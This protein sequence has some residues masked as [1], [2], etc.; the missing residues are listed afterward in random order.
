MNGAE[1]K[2]GPIP[3]CTPPSP[4]EGCPSR[5]GPVSRLQRLGLPE[6][7][8]RFL[9][10]Y[11]EHA[12]D[13]WPASLAH[14]HVAYR[15]QVRSKVAAIRADQKEAESAAE[16][17]RLLAMA[18]RHLDEGHVRLV[19]VGGLPGTGKSTLAAGL[20]D[21]LGATVLLRRDPKGVGRPASRP[22]RS[23]R[24]REGV[25]EPSATVATYREL[26]RRAGVAMGLG[27]TVVLDASWIDDA[28][29]DEALAMA[30]DGYADLVELRCEAPTE[31]AAARVRRRA[32]AG[33][34]PSDATP[35]IAARMA[36]A[37]EPWPSAT[38]V[39]TSGEA[40]DAL[41]RPWSGFRSPAPGR[42]P[43]EHEGH[44]S[45]G[46]TAGP[47]PA[48]GLCLRW[49]TSSMTTIRIA[50][51]AV[52]TLRTSAFAAEAAR[53]LGIDGADVYRMLFAGELEGGPGR[54][55]M[56]YFDEASIEASPGRH[57]YGVVAEPSTGSSTGSL[58]TRLDEPTRASTPRRQRSSSEAQNDIPQIRPSQGSEHS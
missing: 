44:H 18:R 28:W 6:L 27:E 23:R 31:V 52:V 20:G 15:A 1:A 45:T 32:E 7:A 57:G 37:A 46:R 5:A 40:G 26:L 49:S 39:D 14:F 19:L 43:V 30:V 34:D 2:S 4:Y 21:A 53:R 17:D 58:R 8:T 9:A 22:P 51:T 50:S 36:T 38:A 29:R 3:P 11:A 12:D 33:R 55:G 24:L 54:D 16:A 47:L 56:V 35:E 10:A 42:L 48:G 41:A 13:N 25:Y